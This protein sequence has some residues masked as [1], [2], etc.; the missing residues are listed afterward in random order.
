M[1]RFLLSFG[2]DLLFSFIRPN[3]CNILYFTV[4]FYS[5][6]PVW[7]CFA[8]W[9]TFLF[10]FIEAK[11]SSNLLG[12]HSFFFFCLYASLNDFCV[13]CDTVLNCWI[14]V[15][16]VANFVDL[17]DFVAFGLALFV[18]ARFLWNFCAVFVE[19]LRW[20]SILFEHCLSFM[21]FS[22]FGLTH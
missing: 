21:N 22:V 7:V 5:S 14:F 16:T 17:H 13:D 19:F 11:N 12:V 9:F 20:H 3:V 1:G 18:I 6:K 10:E 4:W 2:T 15:V 8:F